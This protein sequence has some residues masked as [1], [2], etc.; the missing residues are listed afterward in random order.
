MPRDHLGASGRTHS[1]EPRGV[2]IAT[3][4]LQRQGGD[5][6]QALI[7][8][9]ALDLLSAQEVT[10]S[11][12]DDLMAADLFVWGAFS[13]DHRPRLIRGSRSETLGCAVFGSSPRS[14]PRS[15][16]LPWLLRPEKFVF[17]DVEVPGWHHPISVASYHASPGDG[18]AECSLQVADWLSS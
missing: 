3:W 10:R 7:R 11:A 12:Y 5:N 18:K 4:N 1:P 14:I 13:L 16:I 17:A 2:R 15:G 9:H 6:R 8:K